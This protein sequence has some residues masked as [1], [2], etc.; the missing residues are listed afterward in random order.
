MML[1]D[2]PSRRGFL[3]VGALA[4]AAAVGL[5]LSS[6]PAAAQETSYIL[7]T[8]TTGGTYYPVGVALA[9]LVKVKLQASDGID[10][11]AISSAGSAENIRLMRD[12][13]A[14]FSILQGLFGIYGRDGSGPIEEDGPQPNLR[15]VSMLWNNVEHFLLHKDL[16]ETGTIEDMKN[17]YGRPY[18]I[19]ARTSGTRFSNEFILG[20][21]GI[22]YEQYDLV[23][24]GYG[25]SIDD[26]QNGAIVGTNPTAGPP[27]GAVTR[28]FA[29]M[30]DDIVFLQFTEEQ[31]A[32]ADGGESLYNLYTI[33]AGTYPGQEEDWI[34]IAQPNF[35][36]VNADVDEEHVYLIT[37]TIFE[38]LPFLNNIHAATNEMSLES[39][40]AGLPFPLHP[41]AARY[42]EEAGLEIPERLRPN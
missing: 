40:L 11:S 9:T 37:K 5:G 20:N 17:V 22:D 27:V 25:P 30:G 26:L 38:N 36:A 10:M 21:L 14:Q 34:T 39:A 24:K 42:F 18:S 3:R 12:G 8:A 23:F 32:A 16:A 7:S 2:N 33:P 15:S 6:G 31:A 13:E 19:G 4:A 35:L 1:Q 28:A 41:G 29:Q